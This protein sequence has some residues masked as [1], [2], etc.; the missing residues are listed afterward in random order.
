MNPLGTL[1]G[2][3]CFRY[4]R[5]ASFEHA[6]RILCGL[7]SD[8]SRC[9]AVRI[10]NIETDP[11]ASRC[12]T[13]QSEQ[14]A[15]FGWVGSLSRWCGANLEHESEPS[16]SCCGA[17][18]SERSA[19]FGWVESFSLW[20]GLRVFYHYK[21]SEVTATQP[22]AATPRV[23]TTRAS[24]FRTLMLHSLSRVKRSACSGKRS[25][26][27]RRLPR[28]VTH[29]VRDWSR[30]AAARLEAAACHASKSCGCAL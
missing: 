20:C 4:D 7:V 23:E 28:V 5:G 1:G 16:A 14:S 12:G 6:K 27:T 26:G 9:G 11:S 10:W 25:L 21:Y 18:R 19:D 2:S 29:G 24:M 13:V 30:T 17:V 8:R 22:S 15:D 3:D